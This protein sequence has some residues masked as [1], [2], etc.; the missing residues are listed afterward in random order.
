MDSTISPDLRLASS[1]FIISKKSA[2]PSSGLAELPALLTNFFP[3][4]SIFDVGVSTLTF[5]STL[6]SVDVG[7]DFCPQEIESKMR[8]KRSCQFLSCDLNLFYCKY[9]KFL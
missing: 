4:K 2:P 8:Q 6:F 9:R 1:L 3:L 7:F 5:V